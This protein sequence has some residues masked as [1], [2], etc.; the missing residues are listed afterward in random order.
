NSVAE[1][2]GRLLSVVALALILAFGPRLAFRYRTPAY[3]NTMAY[4]RSIGA[5]IPRGAV[6]VGDPAFFAESQL[7]IALWI[8]RDAPAYFVNGTESLPALRRA[9]GDRPMFWVGPAGREPPPIRD[10]TLAPVASYTLSVATRRME[11][12]D[13]R[14]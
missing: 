13:E 8:T 14:D 4:V 3:Q 6:I 2:G 10:L 7:H 1:R 9:M 12:Y 11:P 5:L